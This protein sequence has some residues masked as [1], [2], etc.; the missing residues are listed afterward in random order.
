MIC[1]WIVGSPP[2][3]CSTSGLALGRDEHVEHVR[4]CSRVSENPSGWWPESAKQI[5]QSRLHAVFTSI[6]PRQ[7]CCL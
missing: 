5:G 2:E 1:G 4:T 7:E 6:R 3:N